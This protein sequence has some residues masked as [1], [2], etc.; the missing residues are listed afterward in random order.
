M[1]SHRRAAERCTVVVCIRYMD[2]IGLT[3]A[4]SY[5]LQCARC[6]HARLQCM[7]GRAETVLAG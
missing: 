3:H 5:V 7:H 6:R 1:F 4:A 2:V